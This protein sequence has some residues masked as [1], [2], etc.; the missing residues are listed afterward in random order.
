MDFQHVTRIGQNSVW[1]WVVGAETVLGSVIGAGGAIAALTGAAPF[2]GGVALGAAPWIAGA[3]AV[4]G[5]AS[6]LAISTSGKEL[7]A[8]DTQPDSPAPPPSRPTIPPVPPGVGTIM[9][10]L[11]PRPESKKIVGRF[12]FEELDGSIKW[13]EGT[14]AG[15]IV[16]KQ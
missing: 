14:A 12:E 1:G 4:G 6:L 3:G 7:F 16:N 5:A 8:S 13:E 10:V 15:T 2:T 9:I 11:S